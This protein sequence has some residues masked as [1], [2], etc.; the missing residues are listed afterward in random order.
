MKKNY[1]E[2][3]EQALDNI[4]RALEQIRANEIT[5]LTGENGTGKSLIR[6]VIKSR[7]AKQLN[8]DDIKVRA[9]SMDLRAGINEFGSAENAFVKDLAWI[10]TSMNS[11]DYVKRIVKATNSYIILD[12]PEVGMGL[13]LQASIGEWL[14][15]KLPTVLSENLGV[16]VITHSREIVK[17]VSE[18]GNFVNIQ[19]LSIETW[20]NQSPD[21]IDLEEFEKK[22]EA[23]RVLLNH[24]LR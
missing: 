12:E 13:N 16:L 21:A 6:K 15:D 5:I 14:K 24:H 17:R 9:I 8:C 20:L 4:F 7:I 1:S 23:L 10:A 18:I 2:Y 19:G 22:C 3:A 11:L